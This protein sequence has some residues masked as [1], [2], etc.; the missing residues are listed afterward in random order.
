MEK[1]IYKICFTR[2][3]ELKLC[4]N[5]AALPVELQPTLFILTELVGSDFSSSI[6]WKPFG[7]GYYLLVGVHHT[8]SGGRS[9]PVVAARLMNTPA[10]EELL[11]F[12]RKKLFP[13]GE[14]LLEENA[15]DVA[16]Y[17]SAEA[18]SDFSSEKFPVVE[19]LSENCDDME[20]NLLLQGMIGAVGGSIFQFVNA[21]KASLC[22]SLELVPLSVKK[23][24]SFTIPFNGSGKALCNLNVLY[25]NAEEMVKSRGDGWPFCER[26]LLHGQDV[27]EVVALA[28]DGILSLTEA[29]LESWEDLWGELSGFNTVMLLVTLGAI[30]H[31]ERDML[32]RTSA[33]DTLLSL[34]W[35][36]KV[37]KECFEQ[38]NSFLGPERTS[39]LPS[40]SP[41][42]TET[43]K[44]G[45]GA[46]SVLPQRDS[47]SGVWRILSL[48]GG[49]SLLLAIVFVVYLRGS[50]GNVL[51]WTISTDVGTLFVIICSFLMGVYLER[52]RRAVEQFLRKK[53]R[54]K[55]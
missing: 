14:A 16:A 43:E 51:H 45:G 49:T 47:L 20:V 9:A 11:R 23:E 50:A 4:Y 48:I 54:R 15:A 33:V 35:R 17:D 28:I 1:E 46:G 24:F 44:M 53:G 5:P 27:P 25:G 34:G 21:S 18:N 6:I 19:S 37:A 13:L 3:G 38:L 42:D 32:P 7:N 30:V 10:A 39:A 55:G 26:N 29:S 41:S 8:D 40:P 36:K 52:F 22:R 2:A 31:A 12:P